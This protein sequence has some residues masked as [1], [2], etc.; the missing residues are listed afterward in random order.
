MTFVEHISLSCTDYEW[1]EW[2]CKQLYTVQ[3]NSI[4]KLRQVMRGPKQRL[5][6]KELYVGDLSL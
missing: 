3:K 1:P 6:V 5:V 2:S 4:P